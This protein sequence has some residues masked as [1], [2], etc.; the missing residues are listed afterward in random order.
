[1]SKEI[2]KREALENEEANI[3]HLATMS[4]SALAEKLDTI[5]LQSEIA[6]KKK[7]TSSIE[8][9][10]IWRSQVIQARIYK[11]ENNIA[12]VPSEIDLAIAEMEAQEE[13]SEQCQEILNE[14]R[15]AVIE[16]E[17]EQPQ[18]KERNSPDKPEQ[19]SLF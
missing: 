19:L 3:A 11:A 7:L 16:E 17:A 1:M 6:V 9:L 10:E 14:T 18:E 8:L 4:D 5:H 15:S 12:D 13:K 2:Q